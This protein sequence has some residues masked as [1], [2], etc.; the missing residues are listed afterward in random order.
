M[1]LT[2]GKILFKSSVQV[3]LVINFFHNALNFFLILNY[4]LFNK[5]V[6]KSSLR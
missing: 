6:S 1:V 4:F 5:V 3:F 2:P